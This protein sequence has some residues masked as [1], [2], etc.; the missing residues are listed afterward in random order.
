MRWD[1]MRTVTVY[2]DHKNGLTSQ[3]LIK[4]SKMLFAFVNKVGEI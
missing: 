2:M 4:P 3:L 1:E